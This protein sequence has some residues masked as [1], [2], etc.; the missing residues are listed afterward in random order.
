MLSVYRLVAAE[1]KTAALTALTGGYRAAVSPEPTPHRPKFRLSAH[2]TRGD[3]F[4]TPLTFGSGVRARLALRRLR[5]LP[6]PL[7]KTKA[8]NSPIFVQKNS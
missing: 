6:A 1:M 7:H 3:P 2:C 5:R 8:K 4:G